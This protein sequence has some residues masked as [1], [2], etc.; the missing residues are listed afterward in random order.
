MRRVAEFAGICIRDLPP[1]TLLMRFDN[2]EVRVN[3]TPKP[4][5]I[6][7]IEVAG[8]DIDAGKMFR[9]K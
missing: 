3:T 2:Q 8:Y 6:D 5:N 1:K 4:L 7:G 9:K